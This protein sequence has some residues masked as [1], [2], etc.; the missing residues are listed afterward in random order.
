MIRGKFGSLGIKAGFTASTLVNGS[1]RL[2]ESNSIWMIHY[3]LCIFHTRVR[4]KIVLDWLIS[5]VGYEQFRGANSRPI[6]IDIVMAATVVRDQKLTVPQYVLS[7]LRD[8]LRRRRKV[9]SLYVELHD[10]NHHEED[11]KHKAFIDRYDWF[12]EKGSLLLD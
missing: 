3:S 6:S 12:P 1:H 9:H 4:Q 5:T 7:N 2:P 8:G 11:L 10:P